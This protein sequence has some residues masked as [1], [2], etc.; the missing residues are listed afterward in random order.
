MPAHMT[1]KPARGTAA[2]ARKARRRQIEQAERKAKEAAKERDY[3]KCRRCRCNPLNCPGNIGKT[4][5]AA[6]LIDK[7]SGGDG[8]RYSSEAK[9]FVALCRDCHRGPRSLHSGHVRAEFGPEMGDGPVV[10]IDQQ[11]GDRHKVA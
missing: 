1:P 9:H 7:Q 6:H 3:Y 2:R 4:I 11:P 5:E 10:F 8:G